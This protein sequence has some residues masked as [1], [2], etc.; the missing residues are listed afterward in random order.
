MSGLKTAFSFSASRI[1]NFKS[2]FKMRQPRPDGMGQRILLLPEIQPPVRKRAS[3]I[4]WTEFAVYP[5]V[6]WLLEQGEPVREIS[7]FLER[8]QS[9]RRAGNSA[10]RTHGRG[11]P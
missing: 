5:A 4:Y 1:F 8:I 10:G 11:F 3:R 2:R 6:F 7:C 9:G